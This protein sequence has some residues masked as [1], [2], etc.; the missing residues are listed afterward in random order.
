MNSVPACRSGVNA[1]FKD[2]FNAKD[3]LTGIYFVRFIAD[4]YKD[5]K[6]L[7]LAKEIREAHRK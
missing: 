1:D 4:N 5:T 3:L 7:I 6:K 2:C